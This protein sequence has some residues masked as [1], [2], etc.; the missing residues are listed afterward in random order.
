ME[1]KSSRLNNST[2]LNITGGI[3]TSSIS[4]NSSVTNSNADKAASSMGSTTQKKRKK[5]VG[6]IQHQRVQQS[7]SVM[8]AYG[9]PKLHNMS[10]I[11]SGSP[12]YAHYSTKNYMSKR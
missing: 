10:V 7:E 6:Y 1:M 9:V 3:T 2:G 11:E 4:S 5:R 12:S 8:K